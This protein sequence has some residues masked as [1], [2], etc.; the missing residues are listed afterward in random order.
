MPIVT[1][2][3]K[4]KQWLGKHLREVGSWYRCLKSIYVRQ[5]MIRSSLREMGSELR[6]GV[7]REGK[8]DPVVAPGPLPLEA[9]SVGL[10]VEARRSGQGGKRGR[11]LLGGRNELARRLAD[12]LRA[13]GASHLGKPALDRDG[14]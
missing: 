9:R 12:L 3:R 2:S 11:G 5:D 13:V 10:G 14:L 1:I 7:R 6:A 8:K 4:R